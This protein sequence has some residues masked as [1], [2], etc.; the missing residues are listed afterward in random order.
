MRRTSKSEPALPAESEAQA[1]TV[2]PRRTPGKG[3]PTPTRREAQGRRTGPVA[4]P[5][6]TRR[7][8]YKRLRSKGTSRRQ[9]VKDAMAA[10]DDRYLTARDKG[11]ARALARDIVDSRR[12]VGSIFML[13]ALLVLI[14]YA[15]PA[16]IRSFAMS[17]VLVVFLLV[18]VDSFAL[19]RRIKKL[20]HERYPDEPARGVGWYGVQ[21]A[22]MIRRWRMPKARV[23]PGDTI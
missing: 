6:Q 3:R 5:P 8:A 7:E 22:M 9:V 21:R 1:V 15:L 10:G 16:S 20:V 12:N 4:P 2:D 23:R 18:A 19:S 11:P 17:V 14:T 13:V